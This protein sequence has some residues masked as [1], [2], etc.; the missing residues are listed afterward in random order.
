M[1]CAITKML[2]RI[3]GPTGQLCFPGLQRKMDFLGIVS[4]ISKM[5]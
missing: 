3:G 1:N 4:G 5:M 2:G